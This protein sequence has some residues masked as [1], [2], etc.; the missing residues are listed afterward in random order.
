MI[1]GRQNVGKSTL[2][3][4]LVR[5]KIAIV[6]SQPGVTRDYIEKEIP[7]DGKLFNLIDTGGIT[8]DKNKNDME[9]IV[10]LRSMNIID[11]ASLVLFIVDTSGITP[12]DEEISRIIRKRNKK[13]LVVI[14]KVDQSENIIKTEFFAEFYQ[15]GFD[16]I[17]PVSAT[18]RKNFNAL[19]EAILDNCKETILEEETEETIKMAIVGKPNVGKSSILNKILNADRS[20][21][22]EI[23]G[24][25]RDSLDVTM[26]HDGKSITLIDTAGIRRKSKVSQDVEYYSVNRAIKSI[27]RADVVLV[28][29]SADE[30]ISIQDKKILYLIYESRKSAVVIINKWDL[31]SPKASPSDYEKSMKLR[32]PVIS[33]LPFIF[34]S[35]KTGIR[36]ARILPKALEVYTNYSLRVPTNE[37][38][39]FIHNILNKYSPPGAGGMIKIFYGTQVK[40]RPPLFVFFTNKPNKIKSNYERFLINKLRER[41]NFEGSPVNLKF[42]K[43]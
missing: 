5:K 33:H 8:Q 14:N 3:N 17:I 28:I 23:P 13:C 2:F 12:M 25:T 29:I 38:N 36:I 19:F 15:L 27:K 18:H 40:E 43:K 30:G 26:E 24:T 37:L 6:S 16:T 34:A 31:M 32:L 10:S 21:V 7:I 11:K 39:L 35:A 20:L 42:K 4:A 9:Y 22:T 41:F 1:I